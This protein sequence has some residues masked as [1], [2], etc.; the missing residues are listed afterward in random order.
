[1]YVPKRTVVGPFQAHNAGPDEPLVLSSMFLSGK[2]QNEDCA[3][4]VQGANLT[5]RW[6][7][8]EL[9]PSQHS[10]ILSTTLHT[11]GHILFMPPLSVLADESAV[12]DTQTDLQSELS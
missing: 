6:T 2:V 11:A 5:A 12:S 9:N 1:M 3:T 8:G 10:G 4:G 7:A